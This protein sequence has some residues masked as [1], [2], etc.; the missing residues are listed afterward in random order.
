MFAEIVKAIQESE[1]VETFLKGD[2][3]YSRPVHLPPKPREVDSIKMTTL[4]GL[5]KFA[6]DL[7]EAN[8]YLHVEDSDHV[9]LVGEIGECNQREEFARAIAPNTFAK[10]VMIPP[11]PGGGV[12]QVPFLERYHNIPDFLVALK[13]YFV[14][15]PLAEDAPEGVATALDDIIEKI[16][17]VTKGKIVTLE[18]DGFTQAVSTKSSLAVGGKAEMPSEFNL[19]PRRSFG[20][21]PV[22][23]IP[24]SKFLLRLRSGD[25]ETDLPMVAL[26]ELTYPQWEAEMSVVVGEYLEKLVGESAGLSVWY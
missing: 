5:I 21:I 22:D 11:P 13:T 12:N 10:N 2:D 9:A 19:I 7:N 15:P 24:T 6:S 8:I 26:Y 4:R 17:N 20:E 25:K 1:K 18:D 23:Q 16:G 3:Y 14:N